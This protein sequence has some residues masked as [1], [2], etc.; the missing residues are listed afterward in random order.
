M[1][2]PTSDL[3]FAHWN[4]RPGQEGLQSKGWDNFATIIKKQRH[5]RCRYIR[6]VDVTDRRNQSQI[7]VGLTL[8]P[9]ESGEISAPPAHMGK[10]GISAGGASGSGV[11]VSSAESSS[12]G[13]RIA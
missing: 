8:N 12:L 5:A 2:E 9:G 13:T 3:H 11:D 1:W 4:A 6:Q 10:P 7:L